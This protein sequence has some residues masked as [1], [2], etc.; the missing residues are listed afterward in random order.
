M[1]D[2]RYPAGAPSASGSGLQPGFDTG[3]HGG[4]TVAILAGGMATRMRPLTESIPKSMLP[5]A[6]MPFIGH[7]LRLLSRQRF[8]RVVL[9]CGHMQ[10]QVRAYVED[11]SAFD[12]YVRYSSDGPQPLGTGGAL[13][14][15]L[16]LLGSKF[17]VMYGDSYL[18]QPLQPVWEAYCAS[19]SSALMTVFRNRNAWDRSNV[20]LLDGRILSYDKQARTPSMQH[21]D[22]GLNCFS[23]AAF[24]DWP[25]GARFDLAEVQRRALAAGQL[26]GFEV[27]QRF[28]EIGS[29][30]GLRETDELLRQSVDRRAGVVQ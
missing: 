5:V 20:E 27:A 16:P 13:R 28:Y 14:H 30:A 21:I 7:Q 26:A 1:P 2:P 8:Y 3:P 29:P 22:Y 15:A 12:V 10:E 6:G 11:G 18:V 4:P 17:L 24:L 23:A 19:G 25:A 9:C